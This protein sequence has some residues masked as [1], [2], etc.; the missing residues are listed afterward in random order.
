MPL[1]QLIIAHLLGDFVFQ[2]NSLIKW[3]HESWKGTFVHSLV[4]TAFSAILVFPYLRS[5]KAF[6][7]L[8]LLFLAHFVQDILKIV[9][10][11]R[12][13][14]KASMWPFFLDQCSHFFFIFI[15]ASQFA[16]LGY[17]KLEENFREIYFSTNLMAFAGLVLFFT[18]ALD[19]VFFETC[20]IKNKDLKYKRDYCAIVKRLIYFSVAYALLT[21][22]K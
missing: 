15:F 8:F 3:K 18:F 4:I 11:A 6:F 5:P 1:F 2:P 7:I 13:K 14:A 10:Q 19:I 17:I 22:G 9:Y 21:L 12:P 20:R 16:K